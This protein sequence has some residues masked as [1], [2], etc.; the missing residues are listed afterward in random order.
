MRAIRAIG[1]TLLLFVAVYLPTSVAAAALRVPRAATVPFV[2]FFTFVT[3]CFCIRELARRRHEEVAQYGINV[4]GGIDFSWPAAD[5]SDEPYSTPN[6]A[7]VPV[8][9]YSITSG[10]SAVW[11]YPCGGR[12]LHSRCRV[13]PRRDCRRAPA[14]KRQ[15]DSR[16][17]LSRLLQSRRNHLDLTRTAPRQRLRM[18]AGD[19]PLLWP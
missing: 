8:R 5:Y 3:A 2:M 9:S 11:R 7:Q 15:P 16:N 17:Y 18:R 4:P 1:L 10:S 19:S 12:S 6:G 13:Y 14:Q